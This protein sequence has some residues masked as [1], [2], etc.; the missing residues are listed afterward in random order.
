MEGLR[1]TNELR[2]YLDANGKSFILTRDAAGSEERRG[3]F[4]HVN[5][6][7]FDG[8]WQ[9]RDA[10]GNQQPHVSLFSAR[11]S[12]AN[13][14][15]PELDKTYRAFALRLR[16]ESCLECHTPANKAE[17]ERLVLLQTPMHAAGEVENVIDAVTRKEMPQDDIGLRK[18]M[19]V[20]HRT[21]ILTAAVSF[22][23]E[24]ARANEWETTH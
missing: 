11:Y 21:A 1:T 15:L 8:N 14:F 18:D 2:F 22:R 24:L 10:D 20:E 6:P 3:T 19:P 17:S 9:W 13:P 4:V 16:D 7:A 12:P 5:T 23:D